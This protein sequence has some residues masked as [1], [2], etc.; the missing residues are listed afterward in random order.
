[1]TAK[2]VL[3]WWRRPATLA[4]EAAM[5]AIAVGVGGWLLLQSPPTLAFGARDWVVVG[6]LQNHT[7]QSQLAAPLDAAFKIGL[8]QSQYVNVIPDIQVHDALKRMER[9]TNTPVNRLIGAQVAM[10]EGARALILPSLAQVGGKIQVSAEVV[11][12][13]TGVTVY[14]DSALADTDGEVLPATDK[15][16]NNLRGKLGESLAS[17]QKT[18]MPL[19]QITTSN[20]DALRALAEATKATGDGKVQQGFILLHEAIKL[21]PHFALAWARLGSLQDYYLQDSSAAYASFEKA[22]QDPDR[23]ST[24]ERLALEA[25]ISWY[26][27]ASQWLDKWSAY[28]RLYP[29]SSA[30][31]DNLGMGR[32]DIEHQLKAALPHFLAAAH[33]RHPLRGIAWYQ[34]ATVDTE[35]GKY[36]DAEAAVAAGRK[37]GTVAPEFEDVLPDLAQRRYSAVEARVNAHA[38]A[39]LPTMHAEKA[40][41][42]A[43]VAVDQGAD[44][45]ALAELARAAKVVEAGAKP[46]QRARVALAQAALDEASH[47]PAGGTAL[48]TLVSEESGRATATDRMAH[49][50][51]AVN[52]A[53]AAML[54][55][56]D[57]DVKLARIALDAAKDLALNHGFY[58][59]AALWQTANCETTFASSVQARI[60]CL[61]KLVDGRE[62]FQTHVALWRAYSAAGDRADAARQ[63]EWMRTHRG[64]AVAELPLQPATIMNLLALRAVAGAGAGSDARTPGR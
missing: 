32:Y 56:R 20:I 51:A 23:L 43:A 7:N 49:G 21:D 36:A 47:Q 44:V 46:S 1:R 26:G 12:P 40:L 58:D 61:S 39:I 53:L 16:L 6:N 34:A 27:D 15:V 45:R 3:P 42:L 19:E 4:A 2:R 41:R 31:Q 62:Y 28:A 18:S 5:L 55:T 38:V 24:R 25:A 52:L 10:R 59:R 14:S 60:A 13:N 57:G 17:I 33:S 9:P 22:L 48:Q 64:Q 37:L 54:A 11:D 50:D 30:A 63:A 8:E 35:L 29:D